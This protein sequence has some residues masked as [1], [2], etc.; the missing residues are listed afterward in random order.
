MHAPH[1]YPVPGHNSNLK[2]FVI[3]K[4]FS[5]QDFKNLQMLAKSKRFFMTSKADS[6]VEH[7]FGSRPI[8]ENHEC[9]LD[10]LMAN[11]NKTRC[12]VPARID[13][14]YHMLLTGGWGNKKE[15]YET[16]VSRARFFQHFWSDFSD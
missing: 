8:N 1:F 11:K 14:G 2:S 6:S 12:V 3:E 4:V 16:T 9:P 5:D 13:V 10:L 7:S 15:S